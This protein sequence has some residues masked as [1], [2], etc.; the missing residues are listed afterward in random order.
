MLPPSQVQ[1][2]FRKLMT[3]FDNLPFFHEFIEPSLTYLREGMSSKVDYTC[4]HYSQ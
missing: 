1:G 2:S 3:H 4:N